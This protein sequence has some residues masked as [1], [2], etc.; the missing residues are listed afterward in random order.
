VSA[1]VS[2][3]TAC[4]H[5]FRTC[6]GEWE[7]RHAAMADAIAVSGGDAQKSA[8]LEVTN[9]P[10]M[11]STRQDPLER[12]ETSRELS[13][14][15]AGSMLASTTFRTKSEAEQSST[16]SQSIGESPEGLSSEAEGS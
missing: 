13:V 9:I 8:L 7:P 5:Q 15:P 2:P 11:R 3:T 12:G 14:S 10:L 6:S 16:S 1:Y 4:T